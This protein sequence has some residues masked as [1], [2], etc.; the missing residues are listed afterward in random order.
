MT[1]PTST[2]IRNADWFA[3]GVIA[4]IVG[5]GILIPFGLIISIFTLVYAVKSKRLRPRVVRISVVILVLV[6]LLNIGHAFGLFSPDPMSSTETKRVQQAFHQMSLVVAKQEEVVSLELIPVHAG[7]AFY[8]DGT[9]ASLWVTNP[10]PL[11]IRTLCFYVDEPRKGGASGYFDSACVIPGKGWAC[12]TGM[13]GGCVQPGKMVTLDRNVSIVI[14]YVGLWPAR[15]VLVTFN[16]I[17]D[18]LPVTL[19][20]FIIPGALSVN[21]AAKFTIA[22][23]SKTGLSLGTVT[24]LKA[25]GS[26]TPK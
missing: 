3:F 13:G 7:N 24:D 22:L 18:K 21:P 26:A 11:G 12:T 5:A 1:Q 23:M 16:G 19:G 10:A 17:T 25:S 14:G 15:D 4:T 6:F 8:P 2:K 20:Y 9:K